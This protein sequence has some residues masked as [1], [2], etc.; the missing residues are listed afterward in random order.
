MALLFL[1]SCH[2][3]SWARPILEA[4]PGNRIAVALLNGQ[5]Q[6]FIEEGARLEVRGNV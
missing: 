4:G 1:L 5:F 6:P 2:D 3:G